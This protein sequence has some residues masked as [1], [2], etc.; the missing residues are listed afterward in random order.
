MTVLPAAKHVQSVLSTILTPELP[1]NPS[2]LFIDC[3]TIA[4]AESK[5]MASQIP[6]SLG[7]FVDAPMSGGVRAATLG[8]LTFMLGSPEQLVPSV[9][10]TLQYM[11]S[12]VLH[13]GSNGAGLA[14][15]LANNYVLALQNIAVAEAMNLGL[16]LGVD[17]KIL[18]NVMNASTGRCWSSEVNNPVPGVV[19][20]AP[21]AVDYDGGFAV[22]LMNKDL[23]QI[24]SSREA[25][26]AS[27]PC[28]ATARE[29][30]ELLEMQGLGRK[31]FSVVY[32]HLAN[33]NEGGR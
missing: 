29:V 18:T 33:A 31:D 25:V 11:G 17:A 4:P 32:R 22:E 6:A 19:E 23:G 13:C 20:S 12:R 1:H 28:L 7:T 16:R 26:A 27:M 5:A 8:T 14:A 30:Y 24:E 21:A 9:L 15:K 3:S 10:Q 2:R